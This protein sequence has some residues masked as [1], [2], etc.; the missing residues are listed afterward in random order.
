MFLPDHAG[1][2][3]KPTITASHKS[4]PVHP[5]NRRT[6]L[7]TRAPPSGGMNG[8]GELPAQAILTGARRGTGAQGSIWVMRVGGEQE[9]SDYKS[10]RL[11]DSLAPYDLKI[12]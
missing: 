5:Q 4:H 12:N 11:S 1:N 6:S 9:D 8:Y 7:P 3:G 10:V 2:L